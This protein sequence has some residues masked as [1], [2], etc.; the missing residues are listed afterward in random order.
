[1]SE[2]IQRGGAWS[3]N[4]QVV[5]QD[6]VVDII[7]SP[8]IFMELVSIL[9]LQPKKEKVPDDYQAYDIEGKID[10]NDIIKHREKIESYYAY[11]SM[12]ENAYQTLSE[13]SV[14]AR[15]T[16]LNNINSC[17]KNCVGELLL[18]NKS[19]ISGKDKTERGK[20][21]NE[22][23]RNNSDAIIDSVIKHVQETCS[24]S[25]TSIN[26]TIEEIENHSELIVFHAFVEC[27][28]LEKPQ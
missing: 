17:Y 27:K 28:V 11:V 20:I 5:I 9:A 21:R 25:L 1:M 10:Y 8:S 6:S 7:R 3:K 26:Y 12:I 23:I 19:L 14:S 15:E 24:K 4:T 22:L 18:I 2:A 16:A 13:T